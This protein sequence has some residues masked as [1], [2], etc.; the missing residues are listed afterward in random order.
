MNRS[1]YVILKWVLIAAVLAAI[2]YA[3]GLFAANG[4]LI[5]VI[6]LG[7]V[8]LAVLAVYSTRRAVPMKYLLPGLVFFAAFQIWPAIFTG[9]TA[10][11]NWG[12]GHSLTKEQSIE[13]ITSSSVEEVQ[14]QPRYALS[15]AVK[16]GDDVATGDP[17]YI[18]TDPE[19]KQTYAGTIDGLGE[20]LPEGD[21]Q[22]NAL[23]RVAGVEGYTILNGRQ[24]NARSQELESFAVPTRDGAA[25]KKVGL[26]E[27]YEG[28]PAATYDPATDR[29]TDTRPVAQGQ[30]PKVY[31]P[32]NAS[33]V[34]VAD[35]NDRLPQGW[36]ENVGFK[37]FTNALTDPTL[38]SGFFK[39]LVWNFAFAVL[40]V[41]T[42]F[43]LGLALALL[44]NDPRL[45]GKGAMRALLILPYALPGFVTALVWASMFNQQFGLINGMTGLGI[46]WLG[47]GNWAKVAILVTNLWLGFPY[48]FIVCTGALQAIPG[49]VKEAAAIDGATGFRTVRSIVMPLVLVAVGPL[50]IASFA[51]NFNNFGLIYLFTEGGPFE[52][53]QSAIGSTD[54]LITYAFRLA[55]SSAAPNFG[56]AAAISIFIFMIVAVLAWVGFR[57]TKAL[58]EVN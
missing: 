1:P 19:T 43:L 29:I 15:V 23:G 34:N 48:M 6:V 32:S 42:T 8:G 46:D 9:A 39:I 44:F 24:V 51:F 20:P 37:N 57:Q 11:T 38:R 27:A 52:G 2:V 26:S 41:L 22:L 14:G 35:P 33:W 10:F 18:L 31:A 50:L 53:G 17:V 30:A 36:K 49:D 12:D 55:F 3:A 5:G 58:E 47:N 16:A 54:L 21:V 28:K 45:K 56:Y 13:A 40:S 4:Q 25:I 7:L